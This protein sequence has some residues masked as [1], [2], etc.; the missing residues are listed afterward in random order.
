MQSVNAPTAPE[1]GE[2]KK[3]G[4]S[5]FSVFCRVFSVTACDSFSGL[6]SVVSHCEASFATESIHF[7]PDSQAGS[8][9]KL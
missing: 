7:K 3:K 4:F 1:R 6:S 2:L 5:A 9:R 8:E